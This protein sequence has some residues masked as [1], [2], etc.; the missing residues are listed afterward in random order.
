VSK[1]YGALAVADSLADAV[2]GLD[3]TTADGLSK[4]MAATLQRIAALPFDTRVAHAV[5]G[6][7]NAQRATVELAAVEERLQ[8]LEAAALR[9]VS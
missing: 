7:M 2:A 6:V 1:A 4:Y 3:L 9:R 5:A 8:A